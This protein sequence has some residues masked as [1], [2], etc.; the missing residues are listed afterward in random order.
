MIA[1]GPLNAEALTAGLAGP[2][3]RVSVVSETEST[4]AD[5][6]ARAATEVDTAGTV[7]LAEHQTAGR[8][9]AGRSWSSVPG[10]QIAMSAAL[11]A[12]AVPVERWGWLPLAVGMAVVDTVTVEAGLKW[13]NDVLA[14]DSAGK[15]A[16]I[17]VEVAM[18]RPIVVIGIGLNL[19]VDPADVAGAVSLR[20][21]GAPDVDRTSVVGT[22]LARMADRI[23]QWERGD[24]TLSADYRRHSLTIGARVR[25]HLAGGCEIVGIAVDIDADG[26]L[27]IDAEGRTVAVSAGDI[28]HLR[29]GD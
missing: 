20:S 5:L 18:R 13:P 8:G 11:D 27:V 2:W 10:Q 15:L 3:R 26:R 29:P 7:L 25:A 14:G 9:R 17:L 12:A 16:G 21:L 24:S 6:L 19:T 23:A 28:V 4:N 1:D 22:L